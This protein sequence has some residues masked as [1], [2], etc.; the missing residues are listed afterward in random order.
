VAAQ[1]SVVVD[2]T[3][4]AFARLQPVPVSAVR[5][6]DQFLT[7]RIRINREVTIPSQFELLESTGRIDNFRRAAGKI[8][9]PFQG[10]YYNDSD[11]YKWLEA[12][13][14]S[15][16]SGPDPA[17][18]A[19]IDTAITEIA[20][21]QRPDGYLNT[22][23]AVER[24]GERWTN[25]DLHE[26][27]CAGHLFQAAVAHYRVTG[28]TRLLDVAC[29]FADHLCETFGPEETGRR[30][31]T[32]G[33]EEVELA[34]VEL[35]R[36][37]GERRYIEQASYFVHARGYGRLAPPYGRFKIDYHQDHLPIREIPSMVG[38]AVRAIYYTAGATD[39][40]AEE[41]DDALL[42]ALDRLWASMMAKKVYV[43]GGLG[44]RWDGEAFGDDYELPNRRAYAETCAAIA[45]LMWSWRL[46]ALRGEAKYADTIEWTLYNAILPGIALDGRTYFYQNPLEDDGS[47]RRKPWFGTACCPPNVARTLA[48]LS[49]YVYSVTDRTIWTHLYAAHSAD[50][51]LPD[52]RTI[53]LHQE[54]NYPWDG[55]IA[56][57]VGTAGEFALRLRIPA[58]ATEGVAVSV[59]GAALAL[60]IV[61]GEYLEIDRAWH[62]G[63]RVELHLPMPVR[64]L[65]SHPAVAENS[66][67][68][69]L[70]RGPLLYCLEGLDLGGAATTDVVI[71]SNAAFA[72]EE[73]PDLLGGVTVVTIDAAIDRS[74]A[75]W[76]GDL[77]RAA[78]PQND[79][80]SRK[81][82]AIPYFVWA[83]REASPMAVWLREG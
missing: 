21:A 35:G 32:D 80:E 54:T 22:Y 77:Y 51:T 70:A 29:R 53:S 71:P 24:A 81:I 31:G 1:R 44:A 52:G 27:Y 18:E 73:Y 6:E 20:A 3:G 12:A 67:R 76:D 30:F 36:A 48:S 23:F 65:V 4:S 50:V 72:A 59:N 46:L 64:R 13:A 9:V 15:L 61:A 79:L 39:V 5:F 28:G 25:H 49:G 47:H 69:A 19:M 83:N 37:T 82:T 55:E 56:I 17:I 75:D 33:H 57:T 40:A 2:T 26:M 8:A 41:G 74:S 16:A 66:G 68:V 58:W 10:L 7:P 42:A 62:A 78:Q 43:T 14:W 11:V 63:D 34:L 45:N 38:H 60:P